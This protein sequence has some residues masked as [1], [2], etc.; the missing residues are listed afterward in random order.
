MLDIIAVDVNTVTSGMNGERWDIGMSG[1]QSVMCVNVG[2]T[3]L[4][5]PLTVV[6]LS[7]KVVLAK[8]CVTLENLRAPHGAQLS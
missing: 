6:A 7:T 1:Y 2:V 4:Y 5:L 8:P 3:M